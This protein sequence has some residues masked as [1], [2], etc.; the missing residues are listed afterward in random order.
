VVIQVSD[1]FSSRDLENF[2]TDAGLDR[3]F[4]FFAKVVKNFAMIS[5]YFAKLDS[6]IQGFKKKL[7]EL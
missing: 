6:I 1:V 4:R 7:Q 5:E 2:L 3:S